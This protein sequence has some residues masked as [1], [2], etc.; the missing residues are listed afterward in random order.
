M[1]INSALK[2]PLPVIEGRSEGKDYYENG[3]YTIYVTMKMNMDNAAQ[4]S[5]NI[6]LND[7]F[8]AA[9]QTNGT[10]GEEVEKLLIRVDLLGGYYTFEDTPI[11]N[12]IEIVSYR[13]IK[14]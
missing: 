2:N 3:R 8:I 14:D 10:N 4:G 13:L 5:S 1:N 6:Y 11:K 12:G 7:K 9:A